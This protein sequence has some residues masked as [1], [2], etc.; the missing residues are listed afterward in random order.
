MK[1]NQLTVT[2]LLLFLSGGLMAQFDFTGKVIAFSQL[3]LNKVLITS[4]SGKQ[5][6]SDIMGNFTIKIRKKD[7]LTFSAEGFDI[8]AEN[9]SRNSNETVF[10]LIFLEGERNEKLAIEN[11]HISKENLTYALENLQNSTNKYAKY[12]NIFDV[13]RREIPNLQPIV[14]GNVQKFQVRGPHSILGSSAALMVVDNMVVD[15]IGFV[16]PS[17]VKSVRYISSAQATSWGSRGSNG[18]IDIKTT[19]K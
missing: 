13:V 2:L 8:L 14:E 10:N 9:V 5:A 19:K 15:D 12:N 16:Q 11:Q 7:K 17:E 1:P 3:P 18:V 6:T 4:E